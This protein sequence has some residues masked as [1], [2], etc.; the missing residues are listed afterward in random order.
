MS[1]HN[2]ICERQES[3]Y[4][5]DLFRGATRWL[6][7]YGAHRWTG[8]TVERNG[9]SERYVLRRGGG[10]ER[11]PL[12]VFQCAI[13]LTNSTIA[14]V[15]VM[16]IFADLEEECNVII[17]QWQSIHSLCIK[18]C[19]V[20]GFVWLLGG[21]ACKVFKQRSP[22]YMI[23]TPLIRPL[24]WKGMKRF[25]VRWIYSGDSVLKV[26]CFVWWSHFSFARGT[27]WWVFR[28]RLW[29]PSSLCSERVLI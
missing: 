15:F 11:I 19:G 5:Q 14:A 7:R 3:I 29:R 4:S 22:H 17:E 16:L 1:N 18:R 25:F 13:A 23:A 8:R 21:I 9:C 24:Q 12:F 6:P 20:E 26:V 28:R 2:W 10:L 27:G